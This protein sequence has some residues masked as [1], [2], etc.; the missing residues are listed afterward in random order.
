MFGFN[1]QQSQDQFNAQF[2]LY[3]L[4]LVTFYRFYKMHIN[5]N[6]LLENIVE[7]IINTVEGTKGVET[8]EGKE[9][10]INTVEGAKDVK[11]VE[12]AKGVEGVLLHEK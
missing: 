6:N 5:S 3:T 1:A 4:V 2:L 11:T 8:V 9:D 7:D 10:I 12:G